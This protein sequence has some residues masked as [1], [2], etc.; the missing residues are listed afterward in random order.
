PGSGMS[1]AGTK[2]PA[3]MP[4]G[5]SSL[6]MFTS[7]DDA[8]AA[9][10]ATGVATSDSIP[11]T[12]KTKSLLDSFGDQPF[13]FESD[14]ANSLTA[15]DPVTAKEPLDLSAFNSFFRKTSTGNQ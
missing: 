9:L 2:V 10:A 12:S 7:T 8:L 14:G 1:P 15:A 5:G 6:D 11:A 4:V 13:K 3:L